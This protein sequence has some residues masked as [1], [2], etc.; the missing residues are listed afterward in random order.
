MELPNRIRV[1]IV[2][3]HMIVRD[4]LRVFLSLYEDLD[5]VGEAGSGE[6][7]L[8]QCQT[9][10]PDVVLVDMMMPGMNGPEAIAKMHDICPSIRAI[11]LTSFEEE[12]LIRQA[13]AAGAIGFLY[14]DVHADKLAQAIRDAHLG[15]ATLD[16]NAAHAL[17]QSSTQPDAVGHDL[18][19]REHEVLAL[20]VQGLTNRTIGEALSISL[21]T[22]RLHVSNILSKLHVSNRTE[23]V[24]VAL[25]NGLIE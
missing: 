12:D 1:M 6:E 5:V 11:A 3:D 14:K 15:R 4:G 21:A 18:T 23:A 25:Q 17:V 2:D 9:V 8:A 19:R 22:V 16:A 20:L 10:A 7:L 24:S 13:L